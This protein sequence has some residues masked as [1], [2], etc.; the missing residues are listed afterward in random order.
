M[1][2]VKRAVALA[3]LLPCAAA[4]TAPGA[5]ASQAAPFRISAASASAS[6]T[7]QGQ[8]LAEAASPAQPDAERPQGA[9]R[10]QVGV[11]LTRVSP[12]PVGE[13]SKITVT[14]LAQNR[15]GHQ[16]PGASIRLR[17]GA[18]PFSSRGQLDQYAE[19]PASQLPGVLTTRPLPGL[20]G[21]G[22]RQGFSFTVPART[23]RLSGFGVYPIGVEVVNAAGQTVGGVTTFITFMP[24][25]RDFT[26]VSVGWVWPLIDRQHRA[27]DETF[28]DD[29]LSKDLARGGRLDDLLSAPAQSKTPVTWAID[30]ALVDDVQRMTRSYTVRAPRS[31]DKT[32]KKAAPAASAW[33]NALKQSA[34]LPSYSYFVTPYAD[35]D[36][37]SLVRNK[38]YSHLSVAYDPKNTG[39]VAEHLGKQ[40]T[41]HIAWPAAGTAGPETLNRLADLD[42]KGGGAFLMSS[43]YFQD[44]P[45]GLAANAT[46]A[47]QA[48]GETKKTLAYDQKLNEI[49]SGDTR[50]PGAAVLTEQRFL[51]E[52]AMIAAEAPNAR[53]TL[54][55]APSRHWNPAPGLAKRLLD[56]T[57]GAPWLAETSL[58][59]IMNARPQDR[60]FQ[61]YPERYENSELSVKYLDGVRG[62]ARRA[63]SFSAVL[64]DERHISYE[65]AIL[66]LESAA[67][68]G[69][70][71]RAHA[72]RDE[73]SDELA[74]DMNRV[75][76]IINPQR[77]RSLA[78]SSGKFPVTIVNE[79]RDQ[80][81]KVLLTAESENRAKLQ[82]G[83]LDERDREIVLDSGQ[84]VQK[85]IPAQAAG[86]GN[87]RV[88]LQLM[89]PGPRSRKFGAG[90][91][92]TI[93][94]T[95]YG[96]LSLLIIGGGL[97]VLFVGVGV[98]AMRARR[99]RKAEAAGE[100]ST[101]EGPANA[102]AHGAAGGGAPGG[103]VAGTGLPDPGTGLPPTGLPGGPGSPGDPRPTDPGSGATRSPAPDDSGRSGGPGATASSGPPRLP[104][105]TPG[106]EPSGTGPGPG[107]GTSRS[108]GTGT[109][110]PGSAGPG[111]SG[112]AGPTSG[113]GP[114]T[115]SAA[116]GAGSTASTGNGPTGPGLPGSSASADA[117]TPGAGAGISRATTPGP[118]PPP[119]PPRASSF[120]TTSE[121]SAS[122]GAFDTWTGST[123][124]GPSVLSGTPAPGTPTAGTP[125]PGFTAA[126]PTIPAGSSG[127]AGAGTGTEAGSPSTA[128]LSGAASAGTD[129]ATSTTATPDTGS[130]GTAPGATRAPEPG[131]GTGLSATGPQARTGVR[132]GTGAEPGPTNGSAPESVPESADE[133]GAGPGTPSGADGPGVRTG[134]DTA[135]TGS[136]PGVRRESGP[137][138]LSDDESPGDGGSTERSPRHG[139]HRGGNG[140]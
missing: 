57:R 78:G 87:F 115:G 49:V 94:T 12:K 111:P 11:A 32:R 43:A 19:A 21:S 9:R 125:A 138:G 7:V 95:G 73:L 81:I 84:K 126:E 48:G 90:E 113:T 18:R 13:K 74:D 24:K 69:R 26:P 130:P 62:V 72:A 133:P 37:I 140:G 92:I 6:A 112:P 22:G 5:T 100:G 93:R 89:T 54:V 131:A 110:T 71:G 118:S 50:T 30:P 42:L 77:R 51:A 101:G 27:N 56:Y 109:R 128:G 117:G 8:A 120:S 139:K 38:M 127:T 59:K 10:S 137:A 134:A 17:Y 25:R 41:T 108:A 33:L 65:R 64:A 34:R 53:R 36:A 99:R 4:A 103:G 3:A 70:Y 63:S 2:T 106:P 35:P 52:T 124:A 129:P 14:G 40:P 107:A 15:S 28:M 96:Q 66:R 119:G 98:R 60:A 61:G 85:W 1:R 68:R 102:G 47:V 88:H 83:Q 23:L 16:L 79:L 86:N 45:Q 46:T 114:G 39:F 91:D 58:D 55:V 97:A 135:W 31:E 105:D 132:A 122:A 44:P 20:Q 29:R 80:R 104:A 123:G 121:P 82:I 76:I 136:G 67:W 75:R 116:T